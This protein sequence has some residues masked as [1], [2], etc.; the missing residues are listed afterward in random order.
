MKRFLAALF[1]LLLF[2]GLMV[3][4]AGPEDQYIGIYFQIQQG[5]TAQA[6]GKLAEAAARYTEA[7]EGL[8]RLQKS[9]P[10]WQNNVVNFRLEY[11]AKK[12][13]LTGP[14][15]APATPITSKP[16]PVTGADAGT[17]ASPQMNVLQSQVQAL[18]ANNAALQAKLRE[19]L[20]ARPANVDPAAVEQ[21]EARLREMAKENEL[22]KATLA[23]RPTVADPNTE[24]KM[25]AELRRQMEDMRQQLAAESARSAALLREKGDLQDRLDKTNTSPSDTNS[26]KA[27]ERQLEE[28]NRKLEHQRLVAEQLAKE[29]TGLLTRISS[30]ETEVA[31]TK[32]LREE[33]ALLKKQV[34]DLQNNPSVNTITNDLAR[35][36]TAAEAQIAALQSERDLL[37]MEKGALEDRVKQLLKDAASKPVVVAA[38]PRP[39]DAKRIRELESQRDSLQRQLDAAV[40][41]LAKNQRGAGEKADDLAKQLSS[42]RAKIDVYEAKPIPYSATEL[43]LFRRT[44]PTLASTDA[45]VRK[46]SNIPKPPP[47]SSSLILEAQRS[48]ARGD[49]KMA[50]EK[51]QQVLR[52]DMSN[53]YTLANLAAIQIEENKYEDAEKN[54]RAALAVANDDAYSIQMLGYLNFRREKF[55]EAL[56]YFSLAAQY[57]P[58][59]AEVQNYLGVTL[60]HKG[61]RA[62]AESAL[63]K[64]L[65]LEPGYGSAHNNLAVIYA[66]Q[67]P[68]QVELARWHYQKALDT[69]HPKNPE[70]EKLFEAKTQTAN[71]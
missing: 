25:A 62:A 29:K 14:P 3:R 38:A 11:L 40:T 65:A 19:A 70:L 45:A 61:Q 42:L 21:A 33:N 35:R 54:L 71:R 60:S 49:F 7:R 48:F 41:E 20:S 23:S 36:L 6:D 37:R 5:D 10:T 30:L 52:R 56:N 39:E 57:A 34:V 58:D 2:S 15:P 63:R 64:A 51:Y 22:L 12:L 46:S 53:V 8:V 66:T 68:P 59:S 17:E 16:A 27:L 50:E 47:G 44:T 67:N 28:A 32:A 43:A 31:A 9:Y 55:D 69:G 1:A 26:R 4:A 18:Q 24:S 13:A